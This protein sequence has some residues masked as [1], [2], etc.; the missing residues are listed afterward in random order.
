MEI[1]SRVIDVG[2]DCAAT[3]GC[4]TIPPGVASLRSA[5]QALAQQQRA[6][7]N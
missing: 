4:V 5:L 7:P 3:M 2:N 6:I 1:G